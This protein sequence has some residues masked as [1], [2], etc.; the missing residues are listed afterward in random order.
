MNCCNG[1]KNTESTICNPCP[2]D[3]DCE[4]CYE[5]MKKAQDRYSNKEDGIL[6][7]KMIKYLEKHEIFRLMELV[8]SA[9]A[10]KE[11]F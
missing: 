9:I 6:L 10:T 7:E 5:E 2:Y 3:G 11:Q 1:E 4:E 8:T